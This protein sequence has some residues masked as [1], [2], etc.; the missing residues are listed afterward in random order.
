MGKKLKD[1][2]THA[3][4]LA[5]HRSLCQAKFRGEEWNLTFEEFCHFWNDKQLWDQ[6][7]RKVTALV[8]TRF[9]TEKPWDRH[10]CCI[11]TRGD[12]LRS[13][14][15]RHWGN[16]DTEYFKDAIWYER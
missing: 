4:N 6:R 7:G 2:F 5:F 1:P 16:D 15:E 3:R 10:N 12:Q 11:I 14:I 9:D 8:L 13:K